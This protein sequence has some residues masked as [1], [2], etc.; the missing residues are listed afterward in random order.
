MASQIKREPVL[1]NFR[2]RGPKKRKNSEKYKD[3][4]GMSE[5][6]LACIR[7]LPCCVCGRS[8]PND[9]HHLKHV[10]GRGTGLRA[11][12]RWAVPMCRADHDTVEK[13]GSRN[14]VAWFKKNGVEDPGW[15]ALALWAATGN[16]EQMVKIIA[17]HTRRAKP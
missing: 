14:E 3:R 9:P 2:E 4:P 10:G 5:K 6:H 1:A 8:G 12:D 16:V 7:Q 13:I 17:A 15:L 11:V